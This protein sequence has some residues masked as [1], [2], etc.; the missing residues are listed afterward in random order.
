MI[1]EELGKKHAYG[2]VTTHYL[3][4][5]IMANK[6]PGIVNGAMA[7]DEKNLLPLYKLIAGK[8]GSSYTFSI[9]ERI[10]MDKELISQARSL[11]AEEHFQLDKLLN[12]T[13]Q[14]LQQVQQKEKELQSL[15][16]ENEKLRKEMLQVMD[17]EKFLPIE[18]VFE[19]VEKFKTQG[20]RVV[21]TNGC[22][23]LLHPGHTRYLAAARALGDVLIK[24]I[25]AVLFKRNDQ[26]AANKLQK[27]IESKFDQ[28]GGDIKP[29]DKVMMKQNHQVG[30]VMEL[31]GKR[32]VV[33]IGLVPMQVELKELVVVKE[34]K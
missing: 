1:L 23:D 27:K 32:A 12:R 11:V 21:F 26:K 30:Q 2:I 18:E 20:K 8:P 17:K 13:E 3:N 5:K 7:F 15:L 34:K 29:G 33:K 31:R 16:K 25:Q 6:T 28:V 9:A 14:D 22:F 19:L 24:N 10:G 4:L